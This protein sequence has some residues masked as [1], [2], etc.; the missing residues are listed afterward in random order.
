[1]ATRTGRHGWQPPH[2]LRHVGGEDPS[3]TR[4]RLAAVDDTGSQVSSSTGATLLLTLLAAP[5]EHTRKQRARACEIKSS[6]WKNQEAAD[7]G[8]GLVRVYFT[9]ECS[10][11][12]EEEQ[13]ERGGQ[14]ATTPAAASAGAAHME[15]RSRAYVR[16][17]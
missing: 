4:P 16:A 3:P 15:T 9:C 7:R 12:E 17:R 10:G 13:E 1:M 6:Y 5:A 2:R 8:G 14:A 11:E